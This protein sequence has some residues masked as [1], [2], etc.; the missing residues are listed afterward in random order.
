[1]TSLGRHNHRYNHGMDVMGLIKRFLT[2]LSFYSK[3]G[4]TF[5]APILQLS[6][7]YSLEKDYYY[8]CAKWT[9]INLTP[10]DLSLYS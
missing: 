10:N 5:R 8:V 7:L 2:G 3:Y 9:S 4:A 6:I 1:M